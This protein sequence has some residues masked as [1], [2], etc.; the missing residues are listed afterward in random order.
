[1]RWWIAQAVLVIGL[2][3]CG[4]D[5]ETPATEP[6]ES[7]EPTAEAPT[8]SSGEAEE[9][10]PEELPPPSD[11]LRMAHV[12]RPAVP[13]NARWQVQ[14]RVTLSRGLIL[15]SAVAEVADDEDLVLHRL[16]PIQGR[17]R[18]DPLVASGPGDD[19]VDRP[20]AYRED[21]DELLVWARHGRVGM[22]LRRYQLRE[23]MPAGFQE[24]IELDSLG[25][26]DAEIARGREVSP[27]FEGTDLHGYVEWDS[28]AHGH[29]FTDAYPEGASIPIAGL[30]GD[31]FE[32]ANSRRIARLR[33]FTYRDSALQ[34]V[35][36][37]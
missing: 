25:E 2:Q 14:D 36:T 8:E 10:E 33:Y 12:E 9:E 6:E 19:T 1:M 18:W 35:L 7:N 34:A 4:D 29:L 22:A 30:P 20:F 37:R 5:G 15:E 23:G 17:R 26:L 21:E 27:V 24:T 32:P 13:A 31:Y 28:V 11:G 16:T 3:G